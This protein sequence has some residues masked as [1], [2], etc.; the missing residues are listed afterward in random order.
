MNKKQQDLL[1][2]LHAISLLY[3]DEKLFND[4]IAVMEKISSSKKKTNEHIKGLVSV[5]YSW[6]KENAA[7][8]SCRSNVH[9]LRNCTRVDGL[10]NN[11]LKGCKN[12]SV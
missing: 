8:I 6:K 12:A 7:R 4:T 10:I 5:W 2:A 3:G 9:T 1:V 11:L